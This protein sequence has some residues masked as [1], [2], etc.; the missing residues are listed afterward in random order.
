MLV[1]VLVVGLVVASSIPGAFAAT[2]RQRAASVANF[3]S[4]GSRY[5]AWQVSVGAPVVL[6]DTAS[7]RRKSVSLPSGC[8]LGREVR[9]D[10][11]VRYPWPAADGRFVLQCAAQQPELLLT[12]ATGTVTALPS[13]VGGDAFLWAGIGARYIEGVTRTP[14]CAQSRSELK[15]GV[16][17]IA[18]YEI[19]TGRVSYRRGSLAPDLDRAGAPPI[20]SRLRT[21]VVRNEAPGEQLEY[22]SGRF[23]ASANRGGDVSIEPCHG[24]RTIL[25]GPREPQ[26]FD[27]RGGTLTWDTGHFATMFEQAPAGGRLFSY[28]LAS[29][30]R[31]SWALPMLPLHDESGISLTSG[32]FGYSSHAKNMVFWIAVRTCQQSEAGCIAESWSVYSASLPSR[33]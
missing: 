33:R 22:S 17:C 7:G 15:S 8:G 4:D 12:A 24:R 9:A 16:T 21:K 10:E 20:C 5:A 26:N 28:D 29:H 32:V 19:A 2:F 25:G 3:V 11:R 6:F 27:A 14:A 13:G 1:L 31:R 30:R 23:V 18:L